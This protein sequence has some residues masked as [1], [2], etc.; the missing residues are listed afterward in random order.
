MAFG[1]SSPTTTRVAMGLTDSE[2]GREDHRELDG[3]VEA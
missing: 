3:A 2:R 1:I